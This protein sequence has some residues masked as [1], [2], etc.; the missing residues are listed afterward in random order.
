M[1]VKIFTKRG[2]LKFL[3]FYLEDAVYSVVMKEDDISIRRV[4]PATRG[5]LGMKLDDET[6]NYL[7]SRGATL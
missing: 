2:L 1:M 4:S 3:S 6:V 7:I 5:T